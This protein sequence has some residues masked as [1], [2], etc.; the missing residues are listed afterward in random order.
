MGTG[1]TTDWITDELSFGIPPYPTPSERSQELHERAMGTRGR[2]ERE[3]DRSERL[4]GTLW[5]GGGTIAELY[6]A[7][8]GFQIGEVTGKAMQ[9]ERR[10]NRKGEATLRTRGN[11][12]ALNRYSGFLRPD[13]FDFLSASPSNEDLWRRRWW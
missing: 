7:L 1:L 9:Q 8:R 10:G 3:V 12:S 2:W 11:S 4:I 5:I 6:D 13:R